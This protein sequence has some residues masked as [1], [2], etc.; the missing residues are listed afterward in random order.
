MVDRC[1]CCGEIV[2][3]GSWMCLN[4]RRFTVTAGGRRSG[5]TAHMLQRAALRNAV[6]IVK[7]RQRKAE[8]EAQAK[9]M[10]LSVRVETLPQWEKATEIP[11]INWYIHDILVRKDT[12]DGK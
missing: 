6:V 9:R 1:V 2:P 7:N 5:K 3:E 12:E 11:K 4:C 10:G 8:L